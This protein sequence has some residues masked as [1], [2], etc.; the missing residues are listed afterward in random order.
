VNIDLSRFKVIYGDKVLKA[1]AL[2]CFE[3][4]ENFDIATVGYR[5]F[6][7][8]AVLVI[9]DNGNLKEI[10]DEAWMFQFIPIITREGNAE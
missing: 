7:M 1:V 3:H 6:A 10:Y 9:D 4:K 2:T 5:S 8:L